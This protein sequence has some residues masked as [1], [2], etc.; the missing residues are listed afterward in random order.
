MQVIPP[1]FIDILEKPLPKKALLL[2]EIGGIW[3]V[4]IKT[5]DTE[6]RFCVSFTIGW[7]SFA[8][9]QSLEFGDFL[10]F[11]FDGDKRFSVTI[12]GKEGCK[13]SIG[14]VTATDRSSSSRVS[15]EKEPIVKPV[16]CCCTKPENRVDKRKRICYSDDDEPECVPAIKTKPKYQGD[17]GNLN[18]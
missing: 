4:D 17:E 7:D 16:S 13:K 3:C 12:F 10:V 14:V 11:S 8:N 6:E 5:E 9:D 1:A 15:D 18:C 2:D